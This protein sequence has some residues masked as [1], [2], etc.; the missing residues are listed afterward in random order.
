MTE[1]K[2]LIPGAD[3]GVSKETPEAA[4]G[5]AQPT[6]ANSPVDVDALRSDYESKLA[7][8]EQDIRNMKSTFQ[9][10]ESQVTKEWQDRYAN[11]ERKLHETAMRGMTEDERAKY[12][13][14]LESE[15]FQSMRER[16]AEMESER[17]MMANTMSAYNFFIQQGVPANLLN[18]SD[19]YD[20]VVNTGWQYLTNELAEL[21]AA[22]ANPQPQPKSEPAPLKQAPGVVTDKGTPASGTTWAALIAEFGSL[23]AVFRAVEEQRLDPS[24]LP[25]N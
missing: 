6:P 9:S 5:V 20:A 4:S 22:K 10:R 25:M 13:R 11:L 2:A 1:E 24:V 23:E 15:E 7:K 8:Y 21:R 3:G 19:G 14:Q 12:E 16:L 18:L 17:A